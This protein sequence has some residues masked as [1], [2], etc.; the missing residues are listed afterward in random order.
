MN[1]PEIPLLLGGQIITKH[2]KLSLV[3]KD[4]GGLQFFSGYGSETEMMCNRFKAQ[5]RD[6]V[7]T[8]NESATMLRAALNTF[9]YLFDWM[10]TP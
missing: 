6:I 7:R 10:E 1:Q 5:A 4:Q 8:P 2:L 9:N 3:L